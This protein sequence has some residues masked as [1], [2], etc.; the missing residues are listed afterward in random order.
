MSQ[1]FVVNRLD[2]KVFAKA[3]GTLAGHDPLSRYPRLMEEVGGQG[4]ER[5]IDWQARGELRVGANGFSQI[6]LHLQATV[7]LALVCQRCLGPADIEVAFD[8]SFRFV[9]TEEQAEAEDE[10][11]EEDVLALRRD[12]N[13]RELIEDELLMA[14]PVVPR[15]EVCPTE[16]KLAAQDPDFEAESGA[17][18]NPFAVLAKLQTGKS[19]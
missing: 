17:R 9:A 16:V 15:H 7:S 5:Q 4:S 11:A 2:V 14:L 13:L 8:R 10:E 18:P 12:F 1:E 3:A 19:S 6:W